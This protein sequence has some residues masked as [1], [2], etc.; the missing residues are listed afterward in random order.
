[1]ATVDD[2]GV[3]CKGVSSM[4]V[5]GTTDYG[6][7]DVCKSEGCRCYCETSASSEGTCSMLNHN[8]YR[9]YTLATAPKLVANKKECNGAETF[10]GYVATVE[11]CGRECRGLSSMFVFGTNHYGQTKCN[12]KGCR[13]YCETSANDDGTCTMVDHNGYRLYKYGVASEDV[14]YESK[15]KSEL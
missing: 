11:D 2:C 9:L 1:M 10:K 14:L 6:V 15:R 12:S 5:Y 13:C 3:A 4:F 8:G 7:K